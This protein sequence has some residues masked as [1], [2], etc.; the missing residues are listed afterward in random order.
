M[1]RFDGIGVGAQRKQ[2]VESRGADQFRACT[3]LMKLVKLQRAR[4]DDVGKP[5]RQQEPTRN[6]M[7][8]R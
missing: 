2:G 4:S 6:L 8:I 1:E 5:G 3:H 7:A